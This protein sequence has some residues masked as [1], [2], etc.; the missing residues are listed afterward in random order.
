M[1]VELAAVGVG[2]VFG[3]PM[4]VISA[5]PVMVGQVLSGVGGTV[6]VV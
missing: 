1:R 3:V 2:L 4:R 6:G 5:R